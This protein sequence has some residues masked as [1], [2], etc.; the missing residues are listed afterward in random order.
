MTDVILRDWDLGTQR[1]I[2]KN[3]CEATIECLDSRTV[4]K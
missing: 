1:Q 3:L 4:R 2:D